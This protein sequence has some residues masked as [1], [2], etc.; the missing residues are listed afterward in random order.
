VVLALI[1]PKVTE[2]TAVQ[3]AEDLGATQALMAL[4]EGMSEEDLA[5]AARQVEQ[6]K[7]LRELMQKGAFTR[8]VSPFEGNTAAWQFA[9]ETEA[10]MFVYQRLTMPNPT[11][12]RA[13]MR[14]L[15]PEKT[16]VCDDGTA[17]SGAE[18]MYVGVPIA[19]ARHDFASTVLHY[20]VQP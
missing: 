2:S 6:E 10:L 18:L 5:E 14:G 19:P 4:T 16:Y 20:T 1:R 12:Y 17:H 13:Y 15:D 3:P 11:P 9:S 7:R 8:L